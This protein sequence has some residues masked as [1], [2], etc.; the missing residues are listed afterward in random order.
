[1][2]ELWA[3]CQELGLATLGDEM[4]MDTILVQVQFPLPKVCLATRLKRR[5]CN[6]ICQFICLNLV[7]YNLPD[8]QWIICIQQRVLQKKNQQQI[9]ALF[10]S[11]EIESNYLLP[12]SFSL[13]IRG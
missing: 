13:S 5:P 6:P 8:Q 3:G 9:K 12:N 11:L 1:M 7:L 10:L 2:S 4:T